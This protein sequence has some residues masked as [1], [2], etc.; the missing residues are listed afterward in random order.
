MFCSCA[1]CGADRVERSGT[2]DRGACELRHFSTDEAILSALC[3]FAMKRC[4]FACNGL[5]ATTGSPTRL[6]REEARARRRSASSLASLAN[7]RTR[8]DP[9]LRHGLNGSRPC[10]S[11]LLSPRFDSVLKPFVSTKFSVALSG[12]SINGIARK[13]SRYDMHRYRHLMYDLRKRT[14]ASSQITFTFR[15]GLQMRVPL[16]LAT[17][18]I[19]GKH[20]TFCLPLE[21]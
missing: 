15:I 10:F 21:P 13:R 18:R 1:A 9:N 14:L 19:Q 16:P 20:R 8:V 5:A 6:A 12:E 2:G 17:M 11:Q 3:D 7:S 4:R